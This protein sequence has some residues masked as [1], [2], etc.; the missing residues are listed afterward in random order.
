MGGMLDTIN[1]IYGALGR[2]TLFLAVIGA[3]NV[4]KAGKV[5]FQIHK[6]G[7][8]IKDVYE[9]TEDQFLGYWTKEKCLGKSEILLYHAALGEARTYNALEYLNSLVFTVSNKDFR[10]WREKR[11]MGGDFVIYSDVK[12]FYPENQHIEF[13]P[14]EVT[15]YLSA[16]SRK[17]S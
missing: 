5:S 13:T 4:S 8:Y 1:D 2:Y 16:D 15:R 17:D 3:L 14:S 11:Q 12:W 10:M 7:V 9:F 6:T